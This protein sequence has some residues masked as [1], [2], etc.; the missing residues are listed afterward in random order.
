VAWKRRVSKIVFGGVITVAIGI[1]ATGFVIFDRNLNAMQQASQENIAWSASQLEREL[2]RFRDSLGV[3]QA[4]RSSSSANI[5]QRFDVL[6]SRI[7]IFQRGEVGE[8]LQKYDRE[9]NVVGRLFEEIKR[10]EVD[11]VSIS[12]FDFTTLAKIHSAIYPYSAELSDLSR[13]IFVGEE[14]NAAKVRAQ[15]RQGANFA[16]YASILT[17]ILVLGGMIY[18]VLEGQLFRKMAHENMVLAER[19]KQASLAKSRFLTMMSHELRTP[20][21]GVLGL[22]AVARNGEP[23]P[24]QKTLLDQADRSANRML[25]MLTDILDFAALENAGLA[26]ES[27]PFFTSELL[28]SLPE[29]LGPVAHQAEARLTV[30]QAENLPVMLKG[31]ATRLRRAYALMITYFLETA[32]ARE[33]DLRVGYND[34]HLNARILVDYL[35]GGWSPDLI[36]GD[37]GESNESFVSE[38]L[39]PSVARALVER[40]GGEIRLGNRDDGKILLEIDVPVAAMEMRRLKVLLDMQSSPMEMICK[41]TISDLPVDF[42]EAGGA[43]CAEVVMM[44]TGMSGETEKLASIRKKCPSALV[45][46]IGRPE[47]PELY[48]FVAEVPLEAALI[49]TR[50]SEVLG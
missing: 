10:L 47:M 16:L 9:T 4:G 2:A 39:G 42:L 20:M 29:L 15:M 26:L 5:N 31:D 25:A 49:K 7:A 37:R 8:R 38:V 3:S 50:L 32:G 44:E 36:F 22:L 48:D 41:S 11:V 1:A 18:F 27:K 28:V 33:I 13:R 40:M 14:E 19:F 45:F 46:G 21:N 34:G 17:G 24:A 12:S 6:W 43:G 35:D 23:D 30:T